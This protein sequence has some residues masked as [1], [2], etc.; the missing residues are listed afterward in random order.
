VWV[1]IRHFSII[2]EIKKGI[3]H[4]VPLTFGIYF[5]MVRH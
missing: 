2:Y 3:A 1:S 4:A 5:M